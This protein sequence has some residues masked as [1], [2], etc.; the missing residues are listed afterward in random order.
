MKKTKLSIIMLLAAISM[1]SF[2]LFFKK[3]ARAAEFVIAS[4]TRVSDR[5]S[6]SWPGT[7]ANHTITFT[8]TREIPPSGKIVITPQANSFFMPFGMAT[9]DLDLGT[10]SNPISGY[11]DR[12]LSTSTVYSSEIVSFNLNSYGSGFNPE[13][14]SGG[15][16]FN[17]NYEDL[18]TANYF[19]NSV[20]IF[21]NNQNNTFSLGNTL[22]NNISNPYSL[23]TSDFNS[24][25]ITDIAV[26]NK[27]SNDIAI[28][29]GQGSGAFQ[30]P[31]MVSVSSS[32][33][34]IAAADFN[35]DGNIDLAVTN[36]G[37][38]TISILTNHASS[39]SWTKIDI[40]SRNT[41]NGIMAKDFNNDTYPDLAVANSGF[42]DNSI[43][44]FLNTAGSFGISNECK[45][46]RSGPYLMASADFN[47]D[48]Y[49]D[50]AVSNKDDEYVSICLNNGDGTFPMN[51]NS[52]LHTR[53]QPYGMAAEDFNR[54]GYFDLVIS[55]Y[56]ENYVQLFLNQGNGVFSSDARKE[57]ASGANPSSLYAADFNNDSGPDFAFANF[58]D[59]NLEAAFYNTHSYYYESS[60]SADSDG[61]EIISN[62]YNGKITLNLNS[63]Y[64]IP[65]NSYVR[66]KI[67]DNANYD[68]YGSRRL[69]NPMGGGSYKIN[70]ETRDNADKTI[71]RAN[72]MI[73]TVEPV[74]MSGIIPPIRSNES[75]VRGSVLSIGTVQTIL[76]IHT[77]SQTN[78]RFATSSNY[79]GATT[80]VADYNWFHHYTYDTMPGQFEYVGSTTNDTFHRYMW[81]G[82]ADG[83]YY[84]AFIRCRGNTDDYLVFFSVVSSG[85]GNENGEEGQTGGGGGGGD[86]GSGS[87]GPGTGGGGGGGGSGGGDGSGTG[88]STGPGGGG[89]GGGSGGGNGGGSGSGSGAGNLQPFPPDSTNPEVELSGWAYPSAKVQILK[90]GKIEKETVS[91]PSAAFKLLF[92]SLAQ[93]VYTFGVSAHD[94]AN[95]PSIVKNTTFWI[96]K[97][98]K[99]SVND[100]FIPPTIDLNKSII[101]P[102]DILEI[103][104]ETTPLSAV[105]IW[106]TP[107]KENVTDAEI[108]KADSTSENNGKWKATLNPSD[109]K[110]ETME[111]RIKA[112]TNFT[113]VGFSDFSSTLSCGIGV[114]PAGDSPCDRADLNKDKKRNLIDFSIMMYHWNT[115]HTTGD[116][117]LDGKVNLIDFSMLMYCWT[118]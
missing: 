97:G 113:R 9:L 110:L 86:G 49:G 35:Q 38:N 89:S 1:L 28:F 90:D 22:N 118:G 111:Y 96:K 57:Y 34:Y 116:I 87:G 21:E 60:A 71:D 3:S 73:A 108:V 94:S 76:S 6:T 18:L 13:T 24:D 78:C 100:I 92:Q 29:L 50:I 65:A 68:G 98:T 106:L 56:A 104:G 85:T 2:F 55:S 11:V 46:N 8:T 62:T 27:G 17:S 69:I 44:I 82:L 36:T 41:P 16:I 23:V 32:P 12:S 77:N 37:D 115:N 75:P 26:V 84:Y 4:L 58:S 48:G 43:S 109:L 25:G 80:T 74:I 54:D 101:N 53:L 117:N 67:G 95:R 19:G 61:V 107:V 64:G 10:T 79:V 52:E 14:I 91:D 7:N 114:T 5:I 59:N 102:G 31:Q 99:T 88:G 70:I 66:L 47:G 103:Y 33:S 45:T 105:Q 39:A 81:N 42:P 30:A 63:S 51:A 93:G 15:R 112:R 20:S 72:A 83:R 40:A